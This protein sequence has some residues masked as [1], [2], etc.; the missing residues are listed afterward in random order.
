ML[1]HTVLKAHYGCLCCVVCHFTAAAAAGKTTTIRA[2]ADLL[3]QV[4]VVAKDPF[5]SGEQCFETMTSF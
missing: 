5:N 3:P 4:P 1:E 2:L